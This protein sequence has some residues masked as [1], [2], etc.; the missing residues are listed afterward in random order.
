LFW[1]LLME[2]M[3]QW[4]ERNAKLVFLFKRE[5]KNGWV[6]WTPPSILEVLQINGLLCMFGYVIPFDKEPCV[7]MFL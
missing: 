2:K 7:I 4:G 3:V 1:V 6:A 5:R